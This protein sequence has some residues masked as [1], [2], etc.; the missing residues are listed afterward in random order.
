VAIVGGGITGCACA[1]LLAGRG[2]RTILLE[3]GRT[4][5]GSTAASTALI[6]QEPDVDFR[7]LARRYGRS[8][9]VR[10]WKASRRAV[11]DLTGAL[12]GLGR[13]ASTRRVPSVYF[14]SSAEEARE[15]GREQTARRRAGL[16]G[17]WISPAGLKRVTG[18]EGA[19][20]IVTEGNAAIDPLA[21]CLA[22]ARGAAASGA[23]LFAGSR[24][25]RVRTTGT[26]VELD[27]ARGLVRARRVVI[28]TG[29][30]TPEFKPLA[31]R[32]RMVTTHVIATPR[33]P[34]S[35]RD[36]MGLGDVMLW[37]TERPYHYARWTPDH[38][39]LFGGRDRPAAAAARGRN[40]LV[41]RAADLADDLTRLYPV[42]AT[43][44]PEYAWQAL[45]AST[46]DGLPYIGTHRRY[47]NHLFALGYGG[48]GMSFGYLA[49]Q[50]LTRAL[51]G[52][53]H[54]DD[55]LFSFGRARARRGDRG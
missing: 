38:R 24:V 2:V 7:D 43:I 55:E 27:L 32:F 30:A 19:G 46:P 21:S 35:T 13:G 16:P 52:R 4:G 54:G 15:L 14:T 5:H 41:R 9:S 20:A 6:M 22:L 28:A 34:K 47:P 51:T 39:L 48:N 1:Y 23:R 3:A 8:T 36:A 17:R 18:I 53:P 45:F 10:I 25:R 42:L 26:G 33:L 31:G 49:A 29:Y 50:V 11:R 37:D 44:R 12:D 40:Q